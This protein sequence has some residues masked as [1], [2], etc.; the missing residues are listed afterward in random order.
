MCCIK[1][2]HSADTHCFRMIR[3]LFDCAITFLFQANTPAKCSTI[4]K[5]C[6]IL[7][8]VYVLVSVFST[9]A[10]LIGHTQIIARLVVGI[11]TLLLGTVY[12][13]NQRLVLVNENDS[14]RLV[15]YNSKV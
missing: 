1:Q 14:P 7:S 6:K 10:L 12:K 3:I 5:L 11:M 4:L 2:L 13:C 8:C 15:F 9:V